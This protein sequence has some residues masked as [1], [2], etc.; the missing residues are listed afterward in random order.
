MAHLNY[1]CQNQKVMLQ[2]KMFSYRI[3]GRLKEL[4][5]SNQVINN[6]INLYAAISLSFILVSAL[7]SI[8]ILSGPYLKKKKEKLDFESVLALFQI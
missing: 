5:T 7:K 2:L 8:S 6:I 3:F 4:Y 1:F